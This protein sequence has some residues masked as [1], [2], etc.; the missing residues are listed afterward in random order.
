[1][2]LCNVAGVPVRFLGGGT[3]LIVGDGGVA[4]AVIAT[5]ALRGVRVLDDRVHVA[6]GQSFGGLVRHAARWNIPVLSGCPGIPGSVGGAVVMN[7]GG[8]YGATGEALLAVRGIDEKGRLFSRDVKDVRCRLPVDGL[9]RHV[10][11]RGQLPPRPHGRPGGGPV[12]V[13]PR[14]SRPSAARNP[15]DS[16][17]PA[18]RSG[19]PTAG[20]RPDG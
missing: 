4:G 15:W 2:A 13:R 20:S 12:A 16:A 8:R 6:A 9:R 10:G 5:R 18:A 3:N 7:A 14:R 1:M 11:D 17:A 19:T